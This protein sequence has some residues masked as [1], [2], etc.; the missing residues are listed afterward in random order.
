MITPA[1]LTFPLCLVEKRNLK[2]SLLWSPLVD[3]SDAQACKLKKKPKTNP[4]GKII[5]TL[6]SHRCFAS[7]LLVAR[8]R[9]RYCEGV[10]ISRPDFRRYLDTLISLIYSSIDIQI[11]HLAAMAGHADGIAPRG[12]LEVE[13]CCNLGVAYWT[14]TVFA[15]DCSAKR[16]RFTCTWKIQ[17]FFLCG[18]SGG[19]FSF[20]PGPWFKDWDRRRTDHSE[21][22]EVWIF[23]V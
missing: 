4:R 10:K 6:S 9:S 11:S 18:P 5:D 16:V 2:I 22:D 19:P 23:H 20:R 17:T 15:V 14:F 13:Q 3:N 8:W 21:N 12:L 7:G 1:T